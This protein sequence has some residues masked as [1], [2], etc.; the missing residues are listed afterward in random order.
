MTD[1]FFDMIHEGIEC[2][3]LED[4]TEELADKVCMELYSLASVSRSPDDITQTV[5]TF[6]DNLIDNLK[7]QNVLDKVLFALRKSLRQTR[8]EL[9]LK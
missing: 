3:T 9:E 2:L 4:F 1:S 6:E 5:Q 7:Q 8:N